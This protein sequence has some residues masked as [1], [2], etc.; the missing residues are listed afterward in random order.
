MTACRLVF[1]SQWHLDRPSA[2]EVQKELRGKCSGAIPRTLYWP[3]IKTFRHERHQQEAEPD[4][5]R[6]DKIA[7]RFRRCRWHSPRSPW[8]AVSQKAQSRHRILL[9][10]FGGVSKSC[11]LPLAMICLMRITRLFH[12]KLANRLLT[13]SLHYAP[14]NNPASVGFRLHYA[15]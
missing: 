15:T 1:L 11:M 12:I 8:A 2:T 10:W 7:G 5:D 13:F 4:K 3:F 9:N 6:G 14:V